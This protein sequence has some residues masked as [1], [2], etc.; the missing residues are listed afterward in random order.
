MVRKDIAPLH[1]VLPGVLR[2]RPSSYRHKAA[3]PD[4]SRSSVGFVAQD[5]GQ[6]FPALVDECGGY[7]GLCYGDFAVLAIA[8]IQEQQ[9]MIADL[10]NK[11]DV[12]VGLGA[13]MPRVPE[14][15][16]PGAPPMNDL[17]V[18]RPE[19]SKR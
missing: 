15:P 13:G 8:A 16:A 10:R 3:G 5:V 6:V 2:L 4:D 1:S 7:L 17:A 11:V 14:G 18:V 12:L 9:E 19:G